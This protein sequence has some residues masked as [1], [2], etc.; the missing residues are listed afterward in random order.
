[1]NMNRLMKTTVVL[2]A[3]A[4]VLSGCSGGGGGSGDEGSSGSSSES[5]GD[6]SGPYTPTG[7]EV[8]TTPDADL[9]AMLPQDVLD[10]GVLNIAVDT[11][12][13]PMTYFDDNKRLIGFDAE[14]GR[15]IAQK[16]D[17]PVSLNHQNFDAVIPSLQAGKNDM[18]ME[19]MNDTIERQKVLAFVDYSHGGFLIMVKKGNPPGITTKAD[20][21]GKTVSIQ[22]ATVQGDLLKEMDCGVKLMEVPNDIDAQTAVRAGQSDA[23]VADAVVTEWVAA[24]TGDGNEYEVVR[25]PENPAGFSPVYSGIGILKERTELIEAVRSALQALMDDGSYLKA[26]ERSNIAPYAIDGAQVNLGDV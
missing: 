10:A 20:L 9:H 24:T 12:Y 25:D 16:L 3:A 17:I 1:M 22:K 8:S 18:I 2:A 14:L 13:P 11:L 21:C 4:L 5:L 26:L 15:L 23:Y 19:G 6:S 7:D